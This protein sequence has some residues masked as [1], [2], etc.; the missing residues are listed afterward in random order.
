MLA[1]RVS[2]EGR[3]RAY[4]NGRS[5][6][7]GDLR[8][9]G[10]ALLSFYGQHEHRKLTLASS[11]LE[12]LDGFCGP[13]QAER[14]AAYAEI[15]ARERGLRE[16]LAALRERA[17]ARDRELDLLEWELGEID[18][19][20][21]SEPEEA[22]LTAERERLRN[23]EGLRHAAAGGIE[24]LAPESG[25]GAAT[26][27]AGAARTLEAMGGIDAALDALTERAGALAVEAE[28]LAAELRRYGEAVDAPPGRLDEVEERL[29]LLEKLKRKH[30]GTIAAVLAHA[31]ACRTRRDELAGA[32]EAADDA[33]RALAAVRADARRARRRAARRPLG[34]R[35]G[36]RRRGRRRAGRPGHGRRDVRGA[37][38]RARRARPERRRRGRVPDRAEPGRPGGPAAR[39]RVG[40]RALARD[41]GADERGRRGRAGHA[42][43]RRGRRRHRRADRARGRRAAARRSRRGGRSSASPTCRRSRRW[44]TATSRSSRTRPPTRPARPSRC[45]SAAPSSASSCGCSAP[46][47][48]TSAA[49]RH[50]KELLKAA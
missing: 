46:T 25:D 43:L 26:A 38:G 15:H 7:A 11:Q 16:E 30:G 18:A 6:T 21:P 32:E 42:G 9:V 41:A 13:E 2:A 12:I 8:D 45:S 48:P 14:R 44:P 35:R 28:D 37:A 20:A 33:E 31:E 3:T 17:G 22:D 36:H 19:A 47:T 50:A 5:A 1:R 27:L 24:A 40:R 49:R 34:G 29:A 10:G 4:L 23:L 39:D